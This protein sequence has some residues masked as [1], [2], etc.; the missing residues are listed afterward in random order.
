MR[1]LRNYKEE[2][3]R[4]ATNKGRGNKCNMLFG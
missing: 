1:K 2:R 3:E 4:G